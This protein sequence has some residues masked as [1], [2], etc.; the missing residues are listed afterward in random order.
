MGHGEADS[1]VERLLDITPPLSANYLQFVVLIHLSSFIQFLASTSLKT[2]IG[3][4]SEPPQ[5]GRT[6]A[7]KSYGAYSTYAVIGHPASKGS[8]TL[9]AGW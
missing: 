8:S 4:R 1:T 2:C 5:S 6:T 3:I 7:S 9:P